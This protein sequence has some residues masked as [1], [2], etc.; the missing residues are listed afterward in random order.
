MAI[1]N[2]AILLEQEKKNAVEI[3]ILMGPGSVSACSLW[4]LRD[5]YLLLNSRLLVISVIFFILKIIVI[6]VTRI[7]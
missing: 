1:N 6:I 5:F 3:V 7:P 2:E 4:N